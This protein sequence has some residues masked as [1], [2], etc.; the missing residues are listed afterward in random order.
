MLNY[1]ENKTIN[2]NKINVKNV[3]KR[4]FPKKSYITILENIKKFIT[5]LEIKNKKTIWADYSKNNTYEIEEENKKKNC[6]KRICKK[7]SI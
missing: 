2:D 6:C 5:K 4:K 7:I 1:F 3:N